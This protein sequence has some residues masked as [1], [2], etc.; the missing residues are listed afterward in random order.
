[1]KHHR[2]GR[3]R[4]QH[5]KMILGPQNNLYVRQWLEF[6]MRHRYAGPAMEFSDGSKEWW[7]GGERVCFE[8]GVIRREDAWFPGYGT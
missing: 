8:S 1:M 7:Q 6:G 3:T 2:H 5:K 4:P